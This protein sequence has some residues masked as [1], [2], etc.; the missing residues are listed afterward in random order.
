MSKFRVWDNEDQ[1]YFNKTSVSAVFMDSNGYLYM[2]DDGLL[3]RQESLI[4]EF[5]T[6]LHD[7]DGKEIWEGDRVKYG[8]YTG[9][10]RIGHYTIRGSGPCPDLKLVGVYY[11]FGDSYPWI[12]GADYTI[13]VIGTIH[14][15]QEV[16]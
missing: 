13:E 7:A 4:P 16:T 1:K 11:D 15:E 6:G 5:S 3:F 9:V 8:D 12:L 2:M 14:D 10:A